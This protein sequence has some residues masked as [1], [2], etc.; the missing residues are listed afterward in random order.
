MKFNF[1]IQGDCDDVVYGNK[2]FVIIE[3]LSDKSTRERRKKYRK[4]V[5]TKILDLVNKMIEVN[6][7]SNEKNSIN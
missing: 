7:K 1:I 2:R 6:K 5:A 3:K 4:K